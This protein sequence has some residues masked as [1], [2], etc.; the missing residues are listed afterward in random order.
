MM[1]VSVVFVEASINLH[2]CRSARQ[3]ANE[4]LEICAVAHVLTF[5]HVEP[6]LQFACP[7]V[8]LVK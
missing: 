4:L 5:F 7:H 2:A 3:S 8:H 6:G 1:L